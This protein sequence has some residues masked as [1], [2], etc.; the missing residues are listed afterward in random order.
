MRRDE[1]RPKEAL[2]SGKKFIVMAMAVAFALAGSAAF[3][4]PFG[5]LAAVGDGSGAAQEPPIVVE[6]QG[7]GN[8]AVIFIAGGQVP[9]STLE[10]MAAE[11]APR[12]RTLL[13]AL[14]ETIVAR[15]G[16][17]P[18]TATALVAILAERG[19]D[20]GCF[21]GCCSA[22][23]IIDEASVSVPNIRGAVLL[24]QPDVIPIM[25]VPI[26]YVA[27]PVVSSDVIYK[28]DRFLEEDR[29]GNPAF[30][31]QARRF[32]GEAIAY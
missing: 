5:P 18:G 23:A 20:G 13:L 6:D 19:I 9:R 30:A 28:V 25:Q 26:V 31:R 7:S 1:S 12:Y 10:A 21:V 3:G 32:R 11:L 14:D 8:V 16:G 15:L 2:M 4:V 17:I 24:G 22:A 29:M 27:G